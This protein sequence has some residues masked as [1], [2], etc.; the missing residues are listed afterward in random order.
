MLL[1]RPSFLQDQHMMVPSLRRPHMHFT[2]QRYLI[3]IVNLPDSDLEPGHRD[4]GT[5]TFSEFPAPGVSCRMP[6]FQ[7]RI[8]QRPLSS[9]SPSMAGQLF[10]ADPWSVL[11]TALMLLQTVQLMVLATMTHLPSPGLLPPAADMCLLSSP[12]G[13]PRYLQSTSTA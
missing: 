1:H 11:P 13:S 10:Q 5:R 6:S 7:A 3:G 8:R 9:Q 2:Y 12:C 4:C